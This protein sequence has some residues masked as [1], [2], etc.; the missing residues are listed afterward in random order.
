[1]VGIIANG[2]SISWNTPTSVLSCGKSAMLK[3]TPEGHLVVRAGKHLEVTIKKGQYQPRFQVDHL[4]FYVTQHQDLSPQSH[5]ILGGSFRGNT[6][7][8][9]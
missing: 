1:M 5:G 9:V 4:D 2:K 8:N 3:V 6:P 7:C